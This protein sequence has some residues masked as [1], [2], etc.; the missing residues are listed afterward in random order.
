MGEVHMNK[1]RVGEDRGSK[2]MD[3]CPFTAIDFGSSAFLHLISISLILFLCC[4]LY[5]LF[6]FSRCTLFEKL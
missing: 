5:L 2:E 6:V 3:R 1:G 4:P